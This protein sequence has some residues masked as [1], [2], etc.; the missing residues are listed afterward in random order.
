MKYSTDSYVKA[1][2]DSCQD[3]NEK[4]ATEIVQKFVRALHK[5]GDDARAKNIIRA[6]GAESLKRKGA[7]EIT[8]EFARRQKTETISAF[9]KLFGAEDRVVIKTNPT[10][11]AGV[12]VSIDGSREF[13]GTL[14]GKLKAMFKN[15]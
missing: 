15:S 10:L 3:R 2:I 9:K 12:R 14:H 4:E 5:N 7:R 1:L 8:L 13:D 11:I 6:L